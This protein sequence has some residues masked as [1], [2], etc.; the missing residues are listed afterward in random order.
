MRVFAGAIIT[1]L[2]VAAGASDA[3]SLRFHGQAYA[4]DPYQSGLNTYY[5]TWSDL[6]LA[7]RRVAAYPGDGYRFDVAMGQMDLLERTWKDGSYNRTQLNEALADLQ[8]VLRF[9]NIAPQD[10]TRLA[11]DLERLH[12]IRIEDPN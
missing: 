10:R 12:N 6:D 4:P 1:M 9:N 8:F 2:L 5:K 11:Q 7:Q 3:Q